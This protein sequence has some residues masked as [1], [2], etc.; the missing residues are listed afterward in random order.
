M[1]WRKGLMAGA[2][3]VMMLLL[4]RIEAGCLNPQHRKQIYNL[5]KFAAADAQPAT[6]RAV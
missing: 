3:M 1:R 5:K 2:V 6:A 4:L